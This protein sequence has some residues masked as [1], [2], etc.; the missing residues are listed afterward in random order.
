MEKLFFDT[1]TTFQ[2]KTL[3]IQRSK[4]YFG[5]AF[6]AWERSDEDKGTIGTLEELKAK[7]D[8]FPLCA[9]LPSAKESFAKKAPALLKKGLTLKQ[10]TAD[11]LAQALHSKDEEEKKHAQQLYRFVTEL[12]PADTIPCAKAASKLIEAQTKAKAEEEKAQLKVEADA[13]IIAERQNTAKAV[14]SG[15][16]ALAQA[17]AAADA[18]VAAEQ[19]KT[20]DAV[21]A[22]QAALAA[23]KENTAKA[24]A[25]GQEALAQAK[26]AADAAV[27]AEQQKTADA[28][29]AGLVAVAAEKENT[30]KAEAAG[31]AALAQAKQERDAAIAAE[32]QKA[33]QIKQVAADKIKVERDAHQATQ[34]KLDAE[35]QS[36]QAT[37]QKL[38]QENLAHQGTRQKL[39]AAQQERNGLNQR[40]EMAKDEYTKLKQAKEIS[41]GKVAAAE[42]AKAEA[43]QLAA[44]HQRLCDEVDARKAKYDAMIKKSNQRAIIFAAAGFLAA[45]LIFGVIMLV[46]GLTRGQESEQVTEPTATIEVTEAT[47][48]TTEATEPATEPSTEATEPATEPTESDLTNW[49]D[50]NAA[51]WLLENV[52]GILEIQQTGL[53]QI[54]DEVKDVQGYSPVALIRMET[55]QEDTADQQY[56]ILLQRNAEVSTDMAPMDNSQPEEEQ[57]SEELEAAGTEPTEPVETEETEATEATEAAEDTPSLT[58]VEVSGAKVVLTSEEFVMVVYGDDKTMTTALQVYAQIV[59]KEQEV[60]TRWN[61]GE[62]SLDLDKMFAQILADSRWWVDAKEVSLDVTAVQEEI[63]AYAV[64]EPVVLQ[65]TC[66]DSKVVVVE[67]MSEFLADSLWEKLTQDGHIADFNGNLVAFKA[68]TQ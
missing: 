12:V 61:A 31:Q 68:V 19:Q 46:V 22:G 3:F 15:R 20:A 18:A 24:V 64:D 35:I 39:D 56:A 16:E 67:C 11:M 54:P 26:A 34:Q 28:V 21:A 5:N 63:A 65:I 1:E 33:E 10:L 9:T 2:D 62:R 37:Q 30:A 36:H 41:D 6:F 51:Q 50:G 58:A 55:E 17:K 38:N 44:K 57:T 52:P 27:A 49:T 53:D 25:S 43:E 45:A 59:D 66:G 42:R 60:L 29:A 32:Q 23:E 48:P 40:L 47:Q 4:E 7:F 13:A 14:A 8:S